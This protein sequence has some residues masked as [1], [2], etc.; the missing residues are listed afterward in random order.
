MSAQNPKHDVIALVALGL[1][2]LRAQYEA[3]VRT[4]N[5]VERALLNCRDA[6]AE[7]YAGCVEQFRSEMRRLGDLQ[8]NVRDLLSRIDQDALRLDVELI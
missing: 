3:Q 2:D 4:L 6:P 5:H 8:E 1:V 7:T